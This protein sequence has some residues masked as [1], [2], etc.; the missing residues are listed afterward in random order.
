[1]PLGN[2]GNGFGDEDVEPFVESLRQH[3]LRPAHVTLESCSVG[4][5]LVEAVGEMPGY[6]P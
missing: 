3:E 1:M 4:C 5:R 6:E 2:P